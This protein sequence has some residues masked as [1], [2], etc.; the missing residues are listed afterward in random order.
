[1]YLIDLYPTESKNVLYKLIQNV[2]KNSGMIFEAIQRRNDGT[3][4]PV[5]ISLRRMEVEGEKLLQGIIRDITQRKQVEKAL[6]ESEKNLRHLASQLLSAQEDERRRISRELHDELGQSLLMLKLKL[7]N[8]EREI[9]KGKESF[10][11]EWEEISSFINQVVE[12][13]RRLSRNL[14]PS[15]LED[16][17]LSVA[18]HNQIREFT[19]HNHIRCNSDIDQI[20]DFFPKESHINIY[21][22]IQESL[23]NIGK[24]ANASKI[25]MKIKKNN[26]NVSF[27]IEDDGKGFDVAKVLNN[28]RRGLGLR[29]M[30][31]RLLMLGNLEIWSQKGAGTRI[32]FVIPVDATGGSKTGK[33]FEPHLVQSS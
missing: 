14:S 15:I 1:L 9:A 5:E 20:D 13:V 8:I 32:S 33:E 7:K 3:T 21:R 31:E 26:E 6:H 24:Y 17:G 2:E 11:K 28:S 25:E 23:T 19:E 12:S 22:I 16:L 30:Q 29:T 18:L 27:I 10:T 4:F